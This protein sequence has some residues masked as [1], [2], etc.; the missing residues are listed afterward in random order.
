[1]QYKAP[2][3]TRDIFASDI[4]LWHMVEKTACKQAER[5]GYIEIRT[6]AFEQ[7]DLFMRGIGEESE[8]VQKQMYTF[9][10]P[11]GESLT[12]RPEITAPVMRAYIEHSMHKTGA[13]RKFYYLGPSFRYE[14]AQKGRW[15]QF[16]QFGV[17]AIGSES[18]LADVETIV[19][20]WDILKQSGV[21][22]LKL[23]INSIGCPECRPLFRKAL[24]DYITEKKDKLCKDCVR[25]IDTNILRILDCKN[26]SCREA[27]K[28][29]PDVS[30]FLCQTC[31]THFE[32]VKRG[33]K[34]F[35]PDWKLDP[36]LV[37]GLD[38]YTHTV[39]E[40]VAGELGSQNAVGG[41]GRYNLLVEEL[42]G[43]PTPS[44]GFALGLDRI[45][46]SLQSSVENRLANA[47]P[48]VY[49][50]SISDELREP[51]FEIVLRLRRS[52]IPADMDFENRSLKAQFRA[53][54]KS[55]AQFVA[56][57]GPEEHS[58]GL[59]NLKCLADGTQEPVSV[60]SLVEK[61]L[62]KK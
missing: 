57:L 48:T 10:T 2:S 50:V 54:N 26:E 37:R 17:E 6:P 1:L 53:A 41:G 52:S 25:R 46:L 61:I 39:Y 45:V 7:T 3:G 51:A 35:I 15:R 22:G 60:E 27:V 59:V 38:Y 24:G 42:G 23:L 62:G 18:P 44:V 55:G 4:T 58:K 19:L 11:G 56:V 32:V 34:Q 21:P 14:R 13:F 33:V 47:S 9:T 20:A 29:A 12:L 30:Q 16:S 36:H 5:A 8:V 40:F 28:D 31:E 43:P 49:L